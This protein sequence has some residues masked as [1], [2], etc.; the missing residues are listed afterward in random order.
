[1]D[2]I[3]ILKDPTANWKRKPPAKHEILQKLIAESK[4]KLPDDYIALLH[5]SNGGEGELGIEPGWFQIWPTEKVLE[6]NQSYEVDENV[7][8][9]FGFGSNGGGEMLAFDT[10]GN[11]P[12]KVMM[13][14]LIS[15]QEEE[16]IVIAD[17]FKEFLQNMGRSLMAND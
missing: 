2:T 16:A 13:L 15:M 4:G 14:P 5:H 9:F 3:N 12:W 10:R 17:N 7:P 6:F 8:G 11:K 1:M